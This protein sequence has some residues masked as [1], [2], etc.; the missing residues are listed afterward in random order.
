MNKQNLDRI[1]QKYEIEFSYNGNLGTLQQKTKDNLMLAQKLE[2]L[3]IITIEDYK[4]ICEKIMT[5]FT[6]QLKRASESAYNF[7][8]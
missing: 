5:Y 8:T 7:I 2:Q 3:E 6:E 4:L 1:F